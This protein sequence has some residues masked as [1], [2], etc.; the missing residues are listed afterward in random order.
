V[1]LFFFLQIVGFI[2]GGTPL[3]RNAIIGDSAPLRV[4]Q[5][6]TELIGCVYMVL[7]FGERTWSS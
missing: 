5:E 3:I 4:L 6:S 1:D 7:H 2:I